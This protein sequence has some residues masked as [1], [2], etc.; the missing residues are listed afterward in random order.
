MSEKTVSKPSFASKV[1][2]FFK[3]AKGEFKNIVWPSKSS[4]I[5]NTSIVI[6]YCVLIGVTV[7][8]LDML[9]TWLFNL[10]VGLL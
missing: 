5:K 8:V 7:Y 10:V 2:E 6:A 9:F 4:V 3:N 1:K